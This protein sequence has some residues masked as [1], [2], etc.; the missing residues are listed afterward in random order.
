MCIVS[1]VVS[2]ADL[3]AFANYVGAVAFPRLAMLIMCSVYLRKIAGS[4][5]LG[6]ILPV[7]MSHVDPSRSPM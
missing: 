4:L 7:A 1:T 3:D 6:Y 5:R 2:G